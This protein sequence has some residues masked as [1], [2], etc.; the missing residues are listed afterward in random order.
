MRMKI[1]FMFHHHQAFNAGRFIHP[2]LNGD[3]F[4][5]VMEFDH[6]IVLGKNWHGVWIPLNK[7]FSSGH[8]S[9]IVSTHN[10]AD[11]QGV[12]FKLAAISIQNE[13]ISVFIQYD[14][15][16]IDLH[17]SNIFIL[18]NTRRFRRNFGL[19]KD[20]A[21][22]TSNME[23]THGELCARFSNGLCGNNTNRLSQFRLLTGR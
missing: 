8:F 15:F 19:F 16:F 4:D 12:A 18:N 10:S 11:D 17:R 13:D 21:R 23:C 7:R 5:K 3:S 9:T 14:I 2:F 6:T 1:L 20:G 22:S